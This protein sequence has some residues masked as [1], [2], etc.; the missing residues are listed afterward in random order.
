MLPTA[1]MQADTAKIHWQWLWPW[2]AAKLV[3]K[4]PIMELAAH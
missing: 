2:G 3:D 4:P 1:T